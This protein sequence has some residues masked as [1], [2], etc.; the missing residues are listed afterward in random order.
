ML[1]P[2]TQNLCQTLPTG[3]R[4]ALIA[5]KWHLGGLVTHSRNKFWFANISAPK[6]RREMV[7]YSKFVYGS[8]F[9]GH[10]FF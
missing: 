8:E 3:Q 4:Q 10:Y 7:L 1:A 5:P 9:S 6:N 2:K